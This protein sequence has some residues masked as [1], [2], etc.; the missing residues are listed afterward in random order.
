VRAALLD[1]QKQVFLV[2]HTYTPGWHFPGGG[3]DRRETVHDAL[4]RELHE[5][6][7][8]A[9]TG[10]TEL[11]GVYI[12]A[13]LSRRDHV[14]FYVC[15]N[16]R[17]EHLPKVPNMEIRD[18]GFFPLDALPEGTTEATHRRLAEALDGAPRSAEW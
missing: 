12:N 18:C 13:R 5:E 11:F 7:G 2:R 1:E 14:T 4:A 10:A 6:A 3:V 8:V 16:W 15:R 17:Q 9:L